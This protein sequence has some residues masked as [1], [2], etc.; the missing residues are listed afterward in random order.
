MSNSSGP[1]IG[2][3]KGAKWVREHYGAAPQTLRSW[4]DKGLLPCLRTPGGKRLYDIA[5]LEGIMGRGPVAAFVDQIIYAR[6]SSSKQQDELD[7]QIEELKLAYPG[8]QVITDI[9]SGIS[10]KRPG[11][12]TLLDKINSGMVTEVVVMHRDR[13][14]T[15]A[16]DLIEY[17]FRQKAVQLVVHRKTQ[18]GMES[19]Q[20]VAEDLLTLTTTFLANHTEKKGAD[21][22]KK[23]KRRGNE[24]IELDPDCPEPIPSNDTRENPALAKRGIP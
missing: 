21:N 8:R 13:L 20:Q 9:G 14:A 19:T 4:A 17:I 23:R 24:D 5:A 10:F 1:S 16:L 12:R 11:L 7:Q 15:F 22:N 6:V 3:Y 18:E 2:R